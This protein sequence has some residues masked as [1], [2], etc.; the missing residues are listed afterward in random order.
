MAPEK[1]QI[2][3]CALGLRSFG[4]GSRR[5]PERQAGRR[6]VDR[7]PKA[8]EPAAKPAIHIE[9]SEVKTGGRRHRDAVEHD[10]LFP[11]R[12]ARPR[13]RTLRAL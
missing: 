10:P 8:P 7:E 2:I 12:L 4:R 5:P 3:C 13:W 9:K 1:L 6:T 11:E